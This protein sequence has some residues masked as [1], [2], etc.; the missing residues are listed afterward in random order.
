MKI[1]SV[2]FAA[3]LVFFGTVSCRA[4][5]PI[6]DI[7]GTA[8][9]NSIDGSMSLTEVTKSITSAAAKHGWEMR[10]EKPGY[11]VG[12]LH[13]REHEAVVD[14]LYDTKSYSIV[15]KSSQTL[16]YNEANRTIHKNYNSWIRNLNVSIQR[17]LGGAGKP[18]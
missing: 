12:T 13:L 15:Y 2:I 1:S 3:I 11:I 6:Y 7:K 9:P 8:I 16:Q 5:A 18:N 10:V 14:I 17:E 4:G